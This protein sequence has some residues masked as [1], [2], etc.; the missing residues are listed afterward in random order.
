MQTELDA[1]TEPPQAVAGETGRAAVEGHGRRL[2]RAFEALERF[3]VLVESR[4][5]LLAPSGGHRGSIGPVVAAIESDVA[6]VVAVLRLANSLPAHVAG[7]VETIIDAVQLLGPDAVQ[8][9]AERVSTFDFFDSSAEWGATPDHFRLHA[10]AT[11]SA[12]EL[13]ADEIH[14]PHRDRLIVAALLHDV[15]KIVLMNAYPSYPDAV[16]QDAHTPQ[17]RIARER[18]E[19]GVD[20]ALVGGVLARRWGLPRSIATAI[21]RHHSDEAQGDASLIRL[22]DILAHYVQAD[23]VSPAELLSVARS[24]GVGSPELRAV[25]YALPQASG[26]HKRRA[27]EACP[28]SARE[29]EVLRQL[30]EGKA[31]KQIAV[32]LTLSPSTVRTHLH[33]VYAKLGVVD[34]AQAVLLATE[35]GWL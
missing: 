12:A 14:Y 25:L 7:R 9:L 33:N 28:L 21:E 30:A 3:P 19:L 16:H 31:Y 17:E 2:I 6:L 26:S 4:N 24:A 32:G 29:C 10:L 1:P 18:Q 20:H 13:L 15:G 11:R 34:R 8:G 5:R 23:A 27:L 22:A 35:R